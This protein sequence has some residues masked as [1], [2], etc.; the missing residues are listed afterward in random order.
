MSENIN[1]ILLNVVA[2]INSEIIEN[3]IPE[4]DHDHV[5][6]PHVKFVSTGILTTVIYSDTVI[7]D[8]MFDSDVLDIEDVIRLRLD[9]IAKNVYNT[10]FLNSNYLYCKDEG[11]NEFYL[12]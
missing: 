11:S 12:V 3:T 8:S 10:N 1:L 6:L 4:S 5:K 9:N 7:W 2:K